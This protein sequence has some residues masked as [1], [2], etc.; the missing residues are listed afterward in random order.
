[1][2]RPVG[3]KSIF[4]VRGTSLFSRR[5]ATVAMLPSA[6]SRSDFISLGACWAFSFQPVL[7]SVCRPVVLLLQS[8]TWAR[9]LTQSPELGFGFVFS[10]P[11]TALT[12]VLFFGSTRLPPLS[13]GCCCATVRTLLRSPTGDAAAPRAFLQWRRWLTSFRSF[14]HARPASVPSV[15]GHS[16]CR[17]APRCAALPAPAAFANRGL[18][19]C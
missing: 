2:R 13:F 17:T 6:L 19:L 1:M 5:V 14:R 7:P 11:G 10:L 12:F 9:R 15:A 4:A 8:R 3:V 18:P 16:R